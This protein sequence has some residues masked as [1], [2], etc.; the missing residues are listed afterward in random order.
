MPQSRRRV[1]MIAFLR[2]DSDARTQLLHK[3]I[4]SFYAASG[5]P[6]A[7]DLEDFLLS[8]DGCEYWYEREPAGKCHEAEGRVHGNWS[9]LHSTMFK[10]KGLDWPPTE[11]ALKMACG[12]AWHSTY[13]QFR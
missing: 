2:G 1:Y 7:L 13:K 10:E 6:P 9:H 5:E 12:R 11:E 8:E 3:H 4:D